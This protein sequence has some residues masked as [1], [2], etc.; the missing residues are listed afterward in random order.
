[1]ASRDAGTADPAFRSQAFLLQHARDCLDFYARDAAV[2]KLHGG[3][4]QCFRD[5]GSVF[6]KGSRHLVS[7]AR[8]VVQFAW[9]VLQFPTERARYW[10]FLQ[11]TLSFLRS[12]HLVTATGG[13][14]WRLDVDDPSKD[15][16]TNRCYGLAFALLAYSTAFQVGVEE[17]RVWIDETWDTLSARFWEETHGLYADEASADW[18][19]VSPYRGQ[20]ANM[21]ACEAH[22]AAFDATGDERHLF[23][24]RRIAHGLCVRLAAKVKDCT[25]ACDCPTVHS[26]RATCTCI[27]WLPPTSCP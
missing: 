18:S 5:D 8:F 2:D 22:M 10:P 12:R 19:S 11:T 3:L 16:A 7:S 14:K 17:A 27:C 4:H 9:A 21:H 23:R 13:Y 24:A 15:D 25:G 1:M 26:P 20:N 6:D